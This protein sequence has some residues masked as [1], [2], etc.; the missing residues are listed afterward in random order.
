MVF[1]QYFLV[2]IRLALAVM[3]PPEVQQQPFRI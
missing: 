3:T 2:S 1:D